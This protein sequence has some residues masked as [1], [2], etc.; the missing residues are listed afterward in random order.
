[1][2]L[3]K[4]L[5]R[6]RI[7]AG[8]FLNRGYLMP[9]PTALYHLAPVKDE[10]GTEHD[11]ALRSLG[12][13]HYEI[14][15]TLPGREPIVTELAGGAFAKRLAAVI[16]PDLRL[17]EGVFNLF[18]DAGDPWLMDKVFAR[19]NGWG[20]TWEFT[21]AGREFRRLHGVPWG[22]AAGVRFAE[23]KLLTAHVFTIDEVSREVAAIRG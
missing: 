7:Y 10:T 5:A 23:R 3:R 18:L 11:L 1:M 6:L 13:G 21:R 2:P 14:T 15:E 16:G 4:R 20:E 19:P 8:H 22:R 17:D 12:D 9:R